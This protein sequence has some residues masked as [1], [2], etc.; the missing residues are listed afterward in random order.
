[1]NSILNF[2]QD[3]I[4]PI[5]SKIASQKHL[6]AIRDG[7][8]LIMPLT[9][10]G[11]IFIIIGEFPVA[12]YQQFMAGVFGEAFWGSFVWDVAF[13]ATMG[14]SAVV[15]VFGVAYS[16]VKNQNIDGLPA[17]AIALAAYFFLLEGAEGI[18]SYLGAEG[19]FVALV[20]G[21][22][23]GEIYCFFVKKDIVIH[24]PDSVPPT[25]MR[26]FVALIPSIVILVLFFAIR[27]LISITPFGT[28]HNL[29]M[30][31]LQAPLMGISN[32]YFGTLLASLL[33]SILW[34]FGL[35]GDQIVGSV[36]GPIMT[37]NYLANV[38]AFK[39]GLLPPFINCEGFGAIFLNFGGTGSILGLVL[40]CKFMCKSKT[41]QQIANIGL[42]P[43][44][45]NISEP[46]MFGLPIVLNPI[47]MIP[48]ILVTIVVTSVAYL[49]FYLN[50]VARI[51]VSPPWTT[52]IFASGFLATGG[53]WRA[54]V[55]QL[56]LL[57]IAFLIYLPFIK[58]VDNDYLKKEAG[59]PVK[60]EV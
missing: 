6:V 53:D 4:G 3:K 54:V 28:I 39:S 15:A 7:L 25:I 12:A 48:F 26:S 33:N 43:S 18:L 58:I 60:T 14:I 29:I 2:V 55:L 47:M 9:I 50:L 40:A 52:P 1:M 42:V 31:I 19:L 24:L 13:P 32:T 57:V 17:G 22:I 37:A 51:I 59:E 16:F 5:A 10:V 46:I 23:V 41:V 35:H 49:A 30:T 38:E 56:V 11:S 8:V 21:L 36:T 45:F 44:L 20:T 27:I 34:T